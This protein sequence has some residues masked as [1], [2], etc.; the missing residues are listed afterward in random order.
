[1]EGFTIELVDDRSAA[2]LHDAR[3]VDLRRSQFLVRCEMN[4][5]V[6]C[7][8]KFRAGGRE[9]GEKIA[10]RDA[11]RTGEN[12][13]KRVPLRLVRTLINDD[14]AFAIAIRDFAGGEP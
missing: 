5:Q 7:L 8:A 6:T 1:M 14:L 11:C 2:A 4:R 9:D 10:Q 12:R 3:Y 13:F